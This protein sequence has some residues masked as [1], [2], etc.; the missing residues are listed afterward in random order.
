MVEGLR[1]VGA[2]LKLRGY[3][4]RV[5]RF[6]VE[7]VR[8]FSGFFWQVTVPNQGDGGC[9]RVHCSDCIILKTPGISRNNISSYSDPSLTSSHH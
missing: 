1:K 5:L 7:S 4:L 6:G 9:I 3:A 2:A 8:Q